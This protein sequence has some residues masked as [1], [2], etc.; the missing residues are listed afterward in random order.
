MDTTCV[1]GESD[2]RRCAPTCPSFRRPWPSTCKVA[3]PPWGRHQILSSC[4]TFCAPCRE[5]WH[6]STNDG[7]DRLPLLGSEWWPTK[8]A[9]HVSWISFFRDAVKVCYFFWLM[10][11][12]RG[13]AAYQFR[14]DVPGLSV[15]FFAP[16]F[17][18]AR[19][20]GSLWAW[21]FAYFASL[22]HPLLS[23]LPDCCLAEHQVVCASQSNLHSRSYENRIL[24]RHPTAK[25]F[26]CHVPMATSMLAGR[27]E[28]LDV[29]IHLKSFESSKNL[30]HRRFILKNRFLRK[31]YR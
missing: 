8:T 30:D 21:F 18:K 22:F 15:P 7:S 29:R 16:L 4:G 25:I 5:P 20:D 12:L 28:T 24:R 2:D 9:P 27:W 1:T 13:I 3:P 10:A 19:C 23:F 6:D 11:R 17:S 26:R 31:K 14:V